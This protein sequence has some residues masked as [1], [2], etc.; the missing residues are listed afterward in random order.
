MN[1]LLKPPNCEKCGVPYQYQVPQT[2]EQRYVGA[3]YTCPV[4]GSSRLY[5]SRELQQIYDDHDVSGL[6]ED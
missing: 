1:E 4:C 6:L 2:Y 3:M 5:M